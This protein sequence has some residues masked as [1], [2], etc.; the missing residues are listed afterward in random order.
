M[1]RLK[2]ALPCGALG[3][4]R[5]R[6]GKLVVEKRKVP[7]DNRDLARKLPANISQFSRCL[8]TVGAL[9]I[10]KSTIVTVALE[11]PIRCPP[12]AKSRH[13]AIL[14]RCEVADDF[15]RTAG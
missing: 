7:E 11:G 1:V 5:G 8:P 15:V 9:E 10:L 3:S 4:L 12:F 14:R 2:C 6:H 13:A